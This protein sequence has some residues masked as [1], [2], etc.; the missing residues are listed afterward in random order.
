MVRPL[1]V[2]RKN[3]PTCFFKIFPAVFIPSVVDNDVAVT[4]S[5]GGAFQGV[6]VISAGSSIQRS[7]QETYDTYHGTQM[8]WIKKRWCLHHT[9]CFHHGNLKVPPLC[10][11]PPRE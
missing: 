11:P 4:I 5:N 10:H 8:L 6:S 9:P 3:I 1:L 2:N 7:C